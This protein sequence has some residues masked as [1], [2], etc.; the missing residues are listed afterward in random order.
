M[1]VKPR[2]ASR[3]PADEECASILWP[4]FKAFFN[5][6]ETLETWAERSQIKAR[7]IQTIFL[8]PHKALATELGALAYGLDIDLRFRV[9]PLH[10]L[11]GV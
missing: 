8:H 7:R 5:S 1:S 3:P 11:P 10:P 6:G 2:D 9:S 4:L